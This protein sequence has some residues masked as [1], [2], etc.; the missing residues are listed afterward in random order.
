MKNAL[1][2][3]LLFFA[4]LG[5]L[6]TAGCKHDFEEDDAVYWELQVAVG[7]GVTGSPDLGIYT[8]D[9]DTVVEYSY[10]L[11]PGYRDLKVTYDDIELPVSG[12]ITVT[13]GVHTLGAISEKILDIRGKWT[14]YHNYI[15]F[16][17][18]LE[19][20]FDG[21]LFTGESKGTTDQ[22]DSY[23][24]RGDYTLSNDEKKINF[25]LGFTPLGRVYHFEGTIENS[26]TM[27]GTYYVKPDNWYGV[28]E[29]KR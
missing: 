4:L 19:V 18:Y 20:S 26:S 28:W 29:L 12:T 27:R 25:Y 5:I 21:G 14:G 24:G 22:I 23:Q 2:K 8:Y 7:S 6:S 3:L 16:N 9:G 11:K 1:S 15:T 13:Q 17:F 10:A